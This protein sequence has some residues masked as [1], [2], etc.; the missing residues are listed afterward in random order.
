MIPHTTHYVHTRDIRASH[1]VY[2]CRCS[3][4]VD[5]LHLSPPHGVLIP[6]NS[7]CGVISSVRVG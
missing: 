3:W 1:V 4:G 6:S 5:L 2:L 7:E